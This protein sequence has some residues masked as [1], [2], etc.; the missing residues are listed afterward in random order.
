MIRRVANAVAY[1][2]QVAGV[3]AFTY[4]AFLIH[5]AAGF[6]VGGAA[7]VLVGAWVEREAS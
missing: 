3:A 6:L 5:T 2:V 1:A 7:L 4:G